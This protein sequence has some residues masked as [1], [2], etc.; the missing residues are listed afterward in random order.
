M[1]DLEE[2]EALEER[3]AFHKKYLKSKAFKVVKEKVLE[4]DG[5]KCVVCDRTEELVCHHRN[6]SH[7]GCGDEREIADCVTLCKLDHVAIHRARYNYNWFSISH[8]RNQPQ[9][10]N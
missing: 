3:K 10:K 5:H 8:E 9:Q 7:L 4:R 6:Y 2:R 1:A